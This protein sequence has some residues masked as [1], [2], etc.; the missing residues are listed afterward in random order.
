[1]TPHQNETNQ[2]LHWTYTVILKLKIN[3][4]SLN[5]IETLIS[6]TKYRDGN[7]CCHKSGSYHWSE[8]QFTLT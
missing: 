4:L 5:I 2:D 6:K 3:P 1:M 8:Y 7:A